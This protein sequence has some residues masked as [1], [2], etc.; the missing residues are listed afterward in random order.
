ML[1]YPKFDP[2]ALSL[3]PLKVRWYGIMY[4][5]GF[6]FAWGLATWR[7]RDNKDWSPEQISDLIFYAALGVILGGRL[8]FVLFYDFAHFLAQPLYL[9]KTWEGGMSFHGGLLGVMLALVFVAKMQRKPFWV[10]GDFVAP[11]VP[12][13]LAFGR[14]GNFI[15]GEL[16]GRVTDVPWAMVFPYVDAS[17]RHPSQLY[18]MFLE[19]FLLFA[20]VWWFSAK[21]RPAGSVAAVFLIGYG[22]CRSFVEY[23]REPDL[24][25]G[26]L[27]G[28]NITQGQVLSVPLILFGMALFAW[29]Y[30]KHSK[31]GDHA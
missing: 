18:E 30:S 31:K 3:G 27:W 29:A 24:N 21:P 5:I 17:P 14:F 25:I 26:F 10:V 9:F 19:G 4:L 1:T 7:A 13:G 23:F 6:M 28:M 20:I 12:L 22:I 16:W 11:L 2:V 8:G 15:N